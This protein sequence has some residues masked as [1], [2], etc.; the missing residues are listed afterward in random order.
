MKVWYYMVFVYFM[1]DSWVC[2]CLEYVFHNLQQ[3]KQ[4]K[5]A[6]VTKVAP[7]V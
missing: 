7:S 6:M 1:H 3:H 4:L 5:L 2:F